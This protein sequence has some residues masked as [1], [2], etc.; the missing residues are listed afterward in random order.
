MCDGCSLTD[1]G[2]PNPADFDVAKCWAMTPLMVKGGDLL[3][4]T[5]DDMERSSG[6][7]KVKLPTDGPGEYSGLPPS[8]FQNCTN[9]QK[10]IV[11]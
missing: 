1:R 10:R 4:G 11:C 3:I 7:I 8:S 6:R 2:C 9:A 5:K